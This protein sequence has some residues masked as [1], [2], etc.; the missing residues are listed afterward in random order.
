MYMKVGSSLSFFWKIELTNLPG[1]AFIEDKSGEDEGEEAGH[2]RQDKLD[3][4]WE[5][6]QVLR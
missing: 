5:R 3:V 4:T 2:H 6:K 1:L